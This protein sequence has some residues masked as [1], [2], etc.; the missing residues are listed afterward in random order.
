MERKEAMTQTTHFE[1]DCK[2][3][4]RSCN[5]PECPVCNS[6]RL[7]PLAI[8]KRTHEKTMHELLDYLA[9]FQF[10]TGVDPQVGMAFE[11]VAE[12]GRRMWN[13][14]NN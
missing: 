14:R 4:V 11:Y 5:R 2:A 10:Q 9:S 7:P 1:T 13:D 6:R 3:G 8:D 12:I